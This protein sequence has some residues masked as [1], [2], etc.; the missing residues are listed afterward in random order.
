[1]PF[2]PRA[3]VHARSV[4]HLHDASSPVPIWLNIGRNNNT[5]AMISPN[6][7]LKSGGWRRQSNLPTFSNSAT[8]EE[9]P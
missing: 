3:T 2:F 6:R 4:P 5:S 1:V 7:H 8:R 9:D